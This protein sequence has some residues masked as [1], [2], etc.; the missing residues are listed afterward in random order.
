MTH[1]L[2][3]YATSHIE[4]LLHITD[5]VQYCEFFSHC[6]FYSYF[7]LCVYKPAAFKDK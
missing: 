4:Q 7:L 5:I 2:D 3:S 1:W 6:Q